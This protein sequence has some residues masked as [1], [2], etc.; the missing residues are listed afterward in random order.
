MISRQ[1]RPIS[2]IASSQVMRSNCRF[3]PFGPDASQRIHQPV[4]ICVMIVEVLQLHAQAAT[5]HR[6]V[7]LPLDRNE[8][9]APHL[10]IHRAR[11]RTVVRASAMEDFG[12]DFLVH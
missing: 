6:V 11:V 7:F 8:L 9:S 5:G 1:R 3:E 12:F 2:E 10:V 4:R